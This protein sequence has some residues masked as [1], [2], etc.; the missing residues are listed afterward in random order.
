MWPGPCLIPWLPLLPISDYLLSVS[1][2]WPAFCSSHPVHHVLSCHGP[3]YLLFLPLGLLL[4]PLTWWAPSL[5]RV[6]LCL[7]TQM[8]PCL[9]ALSDDNP[10]PLCTPAP[11]PIALVYLLPSS[12]LFEMTFCLALFIVCSSH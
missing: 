6:C 8:S 1:R 11:P 2:H 3:L 5:L 10:L 12:S 4:P 9:T 7:M